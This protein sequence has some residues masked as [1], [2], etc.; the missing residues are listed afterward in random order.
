VGQG[1]FFQVQEFRQND[2]RPAAAILKALHDAES[3]GLAG[4]T[5]I[6]GLEYASLKPG[7]TYQLQSSPDLNQ[8]ENVGGAWVA[9]SDRTNSVHEVS[10]L[11]TFWR[12]SG[13]GAELPAPVL[14]AR[15]LRRLTFGGLV[16][17]ARYQLQ[18]S[19]DLL[20]WS[21]YGAPVTAAA[22]AMVYPDPVSLP[23]KVL[24]FQLKP[25][26]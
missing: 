1:G 15:A 12:V 19:E 6:A 11:N 16:P 26:P 3:A 21:D 20:A 13:E 25:V 14:S 9:A 24:F 22:P 7:A 17:G 8:W 10:G 4:V 2:R 5:I 18:Y 23:M